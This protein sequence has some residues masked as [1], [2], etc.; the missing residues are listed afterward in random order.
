MTLALFNHLWQSTLFALAACGLIFLF[1]RGSSWSRHF[2]AWVAFAQ[3]VIPFSILASLIPAAPEEDLVKELSF[4]SH[5]PGT[6]EASSESSDTLPLAT[7][8]QTPIS[9]HAVFG[10]AW[11]C[12]FAMLF[13]RHCFQYLR[14]RDIILNKSRPA[15]TEWRNLARQILGDRSRS[16]PHVVVA[17]DDCLHA[18]VFGLFRTTI[19]IPEEMERSFDLDDREAFLRHE[20]QHV[21]KYDNLFLHLQKFIHDMLWFHPLAFWLDRQISIEREIMR[22]EEVIKKTNN[23]ES[24]INCLMKAS[25]LK[26]SD[27][28]GAGLGIHGSSFTRRLKAIASY[29]SNTIARLLSACVS[30]IAVTVLGTV[31]FLAVI[32]LQAQAV[33]DRKGEPPAK[34]VLLQD[35]LRKQLELEERLKAE[36]KSIDKL[37]EEHSE[38][39]KQLKTEL[40]RDNIDWE[41]SEQDIELRRRFIDQWHKEEGKGDIHDDDDSDHPVRSD[42]PVNPDNPAAYLKRLKNDLKET[43]NKIDYVRKINEKGE[44]AEEG[45]RWVKELE[46]TAKRIKLEIERVEGKMATRDS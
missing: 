26:L 42:R 21:L 2:I 25:K 43:K 30:V 13:S 10:F 8:T 12:G 23:K 38:V 46:A 20:L 28:F 11:F 22:D 16:F 34:N 19:V 24:Y 31:F 1:R 39:V 32:S 41:L 29:R 33:D 37:T 18:G 45:K 7:T 4:L 27:N 3:F 36:E 35:L 5:V 15:D 14:C 17:D 9:W 6:R 40:V 44:A